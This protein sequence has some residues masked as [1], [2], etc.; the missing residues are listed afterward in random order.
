MGETE[1]E[2]QTNPE[3]TRKDVESHHGRRVYAAPEVRVVELK[4]VI[5]ASASGPYVD[6]FHRRRSA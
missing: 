3:G 5:K 1:K 4:F 6:V 2:I